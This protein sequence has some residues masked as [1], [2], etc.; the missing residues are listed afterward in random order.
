M[1]STKITS[2]YIISVIISALL[3]HDS[4]NGLVLKDET[5]NATTLS[6]NTDIH[7]SYTTKDDMAN[8]ERTLIS[9]VGLIAACLFI[10]CMP[11]CFA[12][13]TK[14]CEEQKSETRYGR[15]M[16]V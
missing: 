16:E 4:V 2:I 1:T 11:W 8:L 15:R 9:I 10:C 12:G 7:V 5:T 13:I 3:S 14:T 6:P